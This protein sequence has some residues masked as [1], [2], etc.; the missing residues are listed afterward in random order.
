MRPYLAFAAAVV[1]AGLIASPASAA[2]L[3]R[4]GGFY[5]D[6]VLD[7]TWSGDANY[8]KTIGFSADGRVT[9]Q[10][11]E[12][13]ADGYLY[14]NARTGILYSDWRLPTLGPDVDDYDPFLPGSGGQTPNGQGAPGAGWGAPGDSGIYSELGWMYYANLGGQPRCSA[15]GAE[16]CVF[17]PNYGLPDFGAGP[18]K[19][20]FDNLE[21][22]FYWTNV[23]AV[24]ANTYWA[25]TFD[26][27]N[28]NPRWPQGGQEPLSYVWL[29]HDGDVAAP[30]PEPATWALIL[31]GFGL[32][33]AVLRRRPVRAAVGL[34]R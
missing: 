11:A 12:F 27:G 32:A 1:A 19:G 34:S 20:P 2:L 14:Q 16:P 15:V 8:A 4:P 3:A 31:A 9:E 17:N 21:L 33:G 18:D 6:T 22:D 23:K 30:V 26:D 28:Q 25:F 5:Y 7:I 10:G 13:L 24:G 29:V